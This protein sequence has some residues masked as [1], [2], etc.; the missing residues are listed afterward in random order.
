[1]VRYVTSS[2]LTPRKHHFKQ[3]SPLKS[4]ADFDRSLWPFD[5]R[6]NLCALSPLCSI[7]RTQGRFNLEIKTFQLGG[8]ITTTVY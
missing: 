1:M 4:N 2:E 7:G 8:H 3:V 6:H 5:L